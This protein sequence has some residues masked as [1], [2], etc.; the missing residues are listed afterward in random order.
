MHDLLHKLSP[1]GLTK[2]VSLIN[3]TYNNDLSY[4]KMQND[5]AFANRL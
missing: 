1:G 4:H 3:K 2:V 5:V